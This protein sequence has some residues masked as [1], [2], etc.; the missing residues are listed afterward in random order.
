MKTITSNANN[1]SVVIAN[2][3]DTVVMSNDHAR[4]NDERIYGINMNSHTLH[5]GVTAPSDWAASKYFFDG[6][7]W[8]L[9]TAWVD[10][11]AMMK[12]ATNV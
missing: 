10:V 4:L 1:A 3:S 9:N 8:T 12:G 11:S 6:T 7:A 5:E 2:D